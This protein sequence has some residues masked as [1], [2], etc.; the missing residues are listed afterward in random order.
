MAQLT[1]AE[2]ANRAGMSER[3]FMNCVRK[4]KLEKSPIRTISEET[5]LKVRQIYDEEYDCYT[6][7]N[8]FDTLKQIPVF[9]IERQTFA[10]IAEYVFAEYNIHPVKTKLRK[11]TLY[12]PDAFQTLLNEFDKII[13]N[14]DRKYQGFNRIRAHYL[15]LIN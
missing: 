5:V 12:S 9:C 3:L 4:L 10:K 15:K 11:T 2:A 8:M 13:P 14:W 6:M 1:K 7:Q